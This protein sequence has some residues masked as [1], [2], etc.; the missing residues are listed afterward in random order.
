MEKRS[1][2]GNWHILRGEMLQDGI[3][4]NALLNAYEPLFQNSLLTI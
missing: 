2:T 1:A 3:S 4:G